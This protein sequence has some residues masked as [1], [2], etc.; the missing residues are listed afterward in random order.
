MSDKRIL[1]VDDEVQVLDGLR[2]LFRKQRHVWDMVFVTSGEAALAELARA[3]FDVIVSDMRMPGMDGATLLRHV[4]ADHPGVVRIVLS[5]HAERAAMVRA[6]SG[7]HQF[8]SKPCEA[9]SLRAALERTCALRDLLGNDVIRRAAGQLDRLPSA[10]AAYWEL[11]QALAQPDVVWQDVAAI[12][13]RDTAMAVKVLQL[14]NSPFFGLSRQ[15]VSVQQAVMYLGVELLK[16]L[17]LGAHVFAMLP[18]IDV[19]GFSLEHF[20]RHAQHTAQLARRFVHEPVRIDEAFTAAMVHDIGQIVLGLGMPA[21]FAA[22]RR[23]AQLSGR[24]VQDVELMR[25]GVTHATVGAYLLGLWGLPFTI[26][27]AVAY[28]HSP[29]LVTGGPREVL[30]ALHVSEAFADASERGPDV[31]PAIDRRFIDDAELGGRLE[32]WIALV[33]RDAEAKISA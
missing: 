3:P 27:E 20:Q 16:G 32:Q 12:V 13:E 28:H 23:E 26:V 9:D 5:G 8:L 15:V 30:A 1:F 17:S 18:A 19:P 29:S 21:E 24:A 25:L 33:R 6:L 7:A 10:P 4:K 2:N 11:A 31:E 14:V 22:V